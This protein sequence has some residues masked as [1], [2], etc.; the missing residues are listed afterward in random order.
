MGVFPSNSNVSG[1]NKGSYTK[2]RVITGRNGGSSGKMPAL[3]RIVGLF[4]EESLYSC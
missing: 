3:L 1:E 4:Q 2:C